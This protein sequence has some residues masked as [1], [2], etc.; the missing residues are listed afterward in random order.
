MIYFTSLY[1]VLKHFKLQQFNIISFLSKV[2]PMSS[3]YIDYL[4]YRY[5]S[6]KL[7]LNIGI[8]VVNCIMYLTGWDL[9][10]FLLS[11]ILL[12]M[13]SVMNQLHCHKKVVSYFTKILKWLCY[14]MLQLQNQ[15]FA[16]KTLHK[17]KCPTECSQKVFLKISQISLENTCAE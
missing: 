15:Q 6:S 13:V 16:N 9:I 10:L 4:K 17:R 1:S 3:T 7:Y 5:K 12:K 14:G 11:Y 8:K 2:T